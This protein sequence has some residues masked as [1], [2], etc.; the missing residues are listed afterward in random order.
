MVIYD[1]VRRQEE[2][3]ADRTLKIKHV[4]LQAITLENEGNHTCKG[5]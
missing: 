2:K 3:E 4:V 1:L 5:V